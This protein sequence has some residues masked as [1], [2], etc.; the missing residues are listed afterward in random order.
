MPEKDLV[1]AF[2]QPVVQC[3]WHMQYSEDPGNHCFPAKI[4]MVFQLNAE[5]ELA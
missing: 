3:F 2:T 4:V 5:G 1:G